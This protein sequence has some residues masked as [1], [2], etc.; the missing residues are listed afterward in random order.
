MDKQIFPACPLS[1]KHVDVNQ[2]FQVYRS[3]LA[4][5]D[6]FLNQDSDTA[7]R[8]LKEG[9]NQVANG[10][11]LFIGPAGGVLHTSQHMEQSLLDEEQ[12]VEHAPGAAGPAEIGNPQSARFQNWQR[13]D[14]HG[15]VKDQFGGLLQFRQRDVGHAALLEYGSG[16]KLDA[17]NTS[18]GYVDQSLFR[19]HV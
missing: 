13:V 16:I 7:A 2:I 11:D 8:L 14:E 17:M 3:G 5:G 19:R 6:T 9:V 10:S 18:M 12:A 15:L 4:F 1:G